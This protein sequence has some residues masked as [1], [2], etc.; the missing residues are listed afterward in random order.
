MEMKKLKL[1]GWFSI[2][3]YLLIALATGLFSVALQPG[4][5]FQSVYDIVTRPLAILLNLFPVFAVLG[6][7]YVLCGNVFWGTAVPSFPILLLSYANLLKI[8]GRE[9]ALVPA[10]LGLLREGLASAANY[11]LNLHIPL[12][13]LILA[14][15]AAVF[16]LGYFIK[17]SAPRLLLRGVLGCATVGLI[18]LMMVFVYPSKAIYNQFT[19]PDQYNIPSVF[20]TLGFNYCFLYNLNL[21]PIDK[22]QGYNASEVKQWEDQYLQEKKMNDMPNI[23]MVM[24]ESFS[25][26]SNEKVFAWQSAEENP[27]YRYNELANSPQAVS[28]HIVVSNIA[29]GT[30]NTEFDV[31]T[32]T[33]TNTISDATTSSF[34]VVNQSVSTVAS[35]LKEAG[36]SASFLH[37]GDSWFYNRSSVYRYLGIE[38]QGFRERFD[39]Q[40]DS[41]SGFVS[42]AAFLR[43]LKEQL[44]AQSSPQ[45]SYSVTIQNHQAYT[46]GKYPDATAA[47]PL[48]VE[49]SPTAM[50]SL[51]VYLRGAKDTSEMVWDLAQYLNESNEPTLLV[52]FGDHLPNLGESNLT[53]RELGLEV[54]NTERT[55][56]LLS[57]YQVPFMIYANNAYCE[58]NDFEA[59]KNAL[60]LPENGIINS[61]YLGA[62]T[63]ELAGFTGYDAYFDYLNQARR[64]LPVFRER[65]HAYILAD[66]TYTD[67]LT[68]PDHLEIL[69]KLDWWQYYKLK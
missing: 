58:Q 8:E 25:D 9:D 55:E 56:S 12:L 43:E 52:F 17:T 14:Y 19:V 38:E 26:L 10:D 32:G 6:L 47:V 53:Y 66:G 18:T 69:R 68:N 16:T 1:N 45:F 57:A 64:A 24:G 11:N 4:P 54:G 41:F 50:E 61:M 35:V 60:D 3:C 48:N 51:S 33:P 20:N 13:L 44:A 7:G 30:A 62:V 49:I 2:G 31:L 15:C 36:Y 27:I 21:Y 23:I 63:M 22:P 39:M 42:D 40:T 46:Y 37:P 5:F 65:E 29:A 34:R 28:G 67:Q 59:Q